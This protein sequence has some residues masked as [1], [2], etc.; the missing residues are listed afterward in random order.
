MGDCRLRRRTGLTSPYAAAEPFAQVQREARLRAFTT[1]FGDNFSGLE[2]QTERFLA[3][4][5]R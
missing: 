5:A 4:N 3:E 1:H 2:Q